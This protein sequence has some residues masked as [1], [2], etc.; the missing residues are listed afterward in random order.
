LR[1]YDL[2]GR[3]FW[4]DEALTANVSDLGW[5]GIVAHLSSAP[6]EHPPLYFLS[7][8]PWQQG[9]GRNEFAFRFF[10][11]FWGVLFVPLLYLL[12][13]RLAGRSLALLAA[14]LGTVSPFLVAYSREAR[15][16]SLLPVL[17]LLAVLVFWTALERERR[18]A[19]WLAYLVLLAAG[20]AT[21]YYFVL[22]WLA[23]ALCLLLDYLRRRR[24]RRWAIAMHAVLP[25]GAAIWL[26]AAPGLRASLVRVLGG[27]TAFELAYKLNKV[28]PALMLGEVSGGEV[29][30]VAHLLA[31][32]GWLLA[33]V[34]V[35]TSHRLVQLPRPAWHFLVLFLVVPLVTALL[36]PYGV[37]GR[38]LGYLLIPLLIFQ[39]LGLVGLR[40]R[41]WAWLG[42]GLVAL[43][44]PVS[45]GLFVH[46]RADN[47]SFGEAMAYIDRR[48]LSGDLLILNQPAQEPL[49]TYYNRGDWPVRYLPEGAAPPAE[50]EVEETMAALRRGHPRLWLGPIGAWTAD[51]ELVVEQ[52]LA[53]NA[54][55]ADKVW[56]PDST[57]VGL[58]F[59]GEEELA[60]V[61]VAPWI[62]GGRIRLQSLAAGS[63][64]VPAGEALLLRFAWRPGFD[65]EERYAV[66]LVLVGEG[67]QIWAERLSEPCAGWCPT[68]TWL[69]GQ[70]R[71]DRHALLVPPGTPPGT[72]RLQAVWQPL[73]GGPPLQAEENGQRLAQVD[74]ARVDVLRSRGPAGRPWLLPDSLG[75]VWSGEVRLLDYAL[76]ATEAL[77][78]QVLQLET[79]WQ[80]T[81]APTGDYELVLELVDG[82]EQVAGVWRLAP[83]TGTYATRQWQLDDYLRGQH[84]LS[85][86]TDLAPGRYHLRLALATADGQ[87][88]EAEG[89]DAGYLLLDQV[90]ILDRPRRFQLP[91]MGHGLEAMVGRNAQ[92]VGYDLD[93]ERAYPG[94]KVQLTLY[95]QAKGPMVR[96][97]K[98]F[99]HLL[100]DR[101]T[102]VA[103]HD[104][105]PGGGC[106]PANTWAE[107]EVIVDE[108]PISL[109]ADLA[110]G[111]YELVVGMYDQEADSRLPAYDGGGNPLTGDRIHIDRVVLEPA[112][113]GEGE[114]PLFE[115]DHGYYLP[116]LTRGEP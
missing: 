18:P 35:W 85:L 37:L 48:G 92:L 13:K 101:G 86:P 21:H 105:Q 69:A 91:E 51:P 98:V 114:Q 74:L 115:F 81:Q 17:A 43:L 44:L 59:S 41:G 94:G 84:A 64:Q 78:G 76:S 2:G 99:T 116:L 33:L 45:Y 57:S 12:G 3:E 47:G 109:G 10:S 56:F 6:F 75:V 83:F 8:Y 7:L 97:F 49:V 4:F 36:I 62:W 61:E 70:V 25:A 90:E 9:V 95:W 34:G 58:Y 15:M 27:E 54:Y 50:G 71:E 80:A 60:P 22:I 40:R 14:L 66:S 39:A 65:L 77:P 93:L 107:G 67:G 113:N 111:Q 63:L 30:L 53:Q 52:W 73:A 38:H 79:H 24:V 103:Q 108:H 106:C 16:Y 19:W 68:D 42:L 31:A 96:P 102:T 1:L 87:L 100:D 5:E 11:V 88:L 28:V 23:S 112:P 104:A 46:Y 89:A 20:L 55:Q 72:Y 110:P 26:L 29:P 82:Q 32:G